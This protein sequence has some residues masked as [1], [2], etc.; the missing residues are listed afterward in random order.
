MVTRNT[1]K[2]IQYYITVSIINQDNNKKYEI[3]IELINHND[4]IYNDL[5]DITNMQ[6]I[7][8]NYSILVEGY[9]GEL[10]KLN[11]SIANKVLLPY[12]HFSFDSL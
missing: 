6:F 10:V 7:Y 8:D 3:E 5:N 12:I 11:Q 9:S 4:Y 1:Y 2:N